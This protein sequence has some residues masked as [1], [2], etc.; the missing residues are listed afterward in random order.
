MLQYFNSMKN[1][2]HMLYLDQELSFTP[3]IPIKTVHYPEK[4]TIIQWEIQAQ[5]PDLLLPIQG[6][7]QSM[8]ILPRE[9]GC[10][11]AHASSVQAGV[12]PGSCLG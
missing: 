7:K 1:K 5:A 11:D 9:S 12:S 3:L 8:P 2:A 4:A 10:R 6:Q